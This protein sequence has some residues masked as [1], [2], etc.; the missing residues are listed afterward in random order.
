LGACV[1]KSALHIDDKIKKTGLPVLHVVGDKSVA[2]TDFMKT[3]LEFSYGEK[4]SHREL[5]PRHKFPCIIT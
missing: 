3:A 4:K 5:I 1:Q 2:S